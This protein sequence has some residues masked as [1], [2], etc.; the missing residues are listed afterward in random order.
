MLGFIGERANR[1]AIE[2]A[3]SMM[4][5]QF[6]NIS[7]GELR[8]LD[9]GDLLTDVETLLYDQPLRLPANFAFLGRALSMLVG[10]ATS[11]S[12]EFNF[13][14]VAT[15]YANQFMRQGGLDSI[16][17]L[18]G[19]SS[20]QQLGRD[21]VREGISLA[22]SV[23]TIPRSLE[24]VLER[25]ERGDLRLI[26]E[27][28]ALDPRLRRRLR[29]ETASGLLSRP[30]PAWVPLGLIGALWLTITVRRRNGHV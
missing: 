21:L 1:E 24:H 12:P 25:A 17:R 5:A 27:S 26:I 16:L 4:V 6:S 11:L 8:Q 7:F 18:F 22:R 20:A 2:Q 28:P 13:M 19:A 9:P 14:E 30:V 23:S 29:R 15:P 10:L 3:I